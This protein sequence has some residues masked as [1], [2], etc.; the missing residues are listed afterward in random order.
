M[1]MCQSVEI[2]LVPFQSCVFFKRNNT[3]VE[4]GCI[5]SKDIYNV[6]K[7]LHFK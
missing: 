4:Q 6:P 2:S 5:D 7:D 1:D 3:F